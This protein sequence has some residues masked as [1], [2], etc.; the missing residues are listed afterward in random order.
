MSH[1][2]RFFRPL[3][4]RFIRP[5]L[6]QRRRDFSI[7]INFQGLAIAAA[8]GL[9]AAALLLSGACSILEETGITGPQTALEGEQPV[10]YTA[11]IEGLDDL[12]GE[13]EIARASTR[14]FQLQSRGAPSVAGL[15]RRAEQDTQEI[16][17]VLSA[18]GYYDAT[19]ES[20]VVTAG[21]DLVQVTFTA[22]P[23]PRYGFGDVTVQ[24][25]PASEE[26]PVPDALAAAGGLA[27]GQPARGE[28]VV[29][30]EAKVV[31]YLR[32]HGFPEAKFV[33]RKAVAQ[34]E[35]ST[36]DVTQIFNPGPFARFGDLEIDP[37][38]SL[39]PDYILGLVPWTKGD[40]YNQQKVDSFQAALKSTGLFD[41]VKIAPDKAAEDD[42]PGP[43]RDLLL[44][45]DNAEQRSIGG[46]L[47]YD[48]DQGPGVR[49]FWRHRNLF[50]RAEDFRAEADVSLDEQKVSFGLTRPRYPGER[51]TTSESLT[52]RRLNDEAFDEK[53]VTGRVGM[54]IGLKRGWTLGGAVEASASRV[55]SD[56]QND[57]AYLVGLPL[58]AR[59]NRTNDPLDATEGYRF[60]LRAGPFAGLNNGEPVQFGIVG[61]GGSVY[62]PLIGENRLVLAMRTE[63]GSILSQ[64]LD[65]IPVNKRFFAGGGASVRGYEFQ[66][67]S[68][69]DA[70][71]DLSGGRFLNENSLEL[72]MRFGESFGV[73]AFADAG[74]VEEEPFPIFAEEYQVGVGGGFRYYSPVGPIRFDLA[75][76]LNRRNGDN[77]FEFY[78]SLGQAF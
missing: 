21:P 30:S 58:F 29:E 35:D 73:V 39:E 34:K 32:N 31:T 65:D 40:I 17:R 53:S 70:Q 25:D 13:R 5:Q 50:G 19:V 15:E 63:V 2:L 20:R 43:E 8:R 75:F 67:I 64:D 27:S 11:T 7:L 33:E 77:F 36:L 54:E 72:R 71:G 45:V 42:E 22:D 62:F 23:G 4:N 46:S 1:L 60:F 3:P 57:T 18:E 12:P 51:W 69:A 47:R 44:S 10:K 66:S 9:A 59:R 78:I 52:F 74:L 6:R 76:P 38:S 56:V 48:T 41:T 24:L 61:G 68:P 26:A 49:A 55:D 16:L 14:T 28:A 37:N